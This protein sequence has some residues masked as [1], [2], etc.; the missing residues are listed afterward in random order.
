MTDSCA[1]STAAFKKA[2]EKLRDA[3][4]LRKY[5]EIPVR[6]GLIGDTPSKT[7]YCENCS[8][9]SLRI[10]FL[11]K[12]LLE[13]QESR[14]SGEDLFNKKCSEAQSLLC[15]T[16]SSLTFGAN[17]EILKETASLPSHDALGKS[18]ETQKQMLRQIEEKVLKLS[19][20]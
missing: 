6:Y 13:M 3:D 7:S 20:K 18:V 2:T 5:V 19:K 10:A 11:E 4:Q 14:R 1:V 8:A 17:E 12:Q 15:S 9:M 16:H